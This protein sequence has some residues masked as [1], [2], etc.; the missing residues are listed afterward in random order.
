MCHSV[1]LSVKTRAKALSTALTIFYLQTGDSTY[2][3]TCDVDKDNCRVLGVRLTINIEVDGTSHKNITSL[4]HS[5]LS[6][7]NKSIGSL[8]YDCHR[9]TCIVS[10]FGI[11][12][13]MEYT[14]Y[15]AER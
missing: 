6:K 14:G 12:Y 9:H 2:L 8:K 10:V 11:P 3:Q 15:G 4:R 13:S 1:T 5:T 7:K